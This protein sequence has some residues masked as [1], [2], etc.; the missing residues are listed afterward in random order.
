MGKGRPKI[1]I[2]W[3]AFD[4]LCGMQCTKREIADFFDVSEDTIDRACKRDHKVNFAVYFAQKAA[5]G[6]I[7]LRRKQ[8]DVAMA[9][10]NTMLIWLGKQYLGQS[11]KIHQT[12][13]G[14]T[15]ALLI[16]PANGSEASKEKP[17]K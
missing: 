12:G 1:Q 9:G 11:D 2:D 17:E 3:T 13:S 8:W 5:K 15:P 6:R 14:G 10:N 7:S 4:K 16:L